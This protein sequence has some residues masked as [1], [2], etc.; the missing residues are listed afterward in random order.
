MSEKTLDVVAVEIAT[1]KVLWTLGP[2]DEA[3]ADASIALAIARQGVEDRFYTTAP[4][5]A[6]HAGD[7]YRETTS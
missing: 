1:R 2:R 5:G 3:G 6:F 7:A 4:T